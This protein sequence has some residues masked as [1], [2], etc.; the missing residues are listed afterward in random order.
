MRRLAVRY[1]DQ[2]RYF[3]VSPEPARLGSAPDNDLIAPFRGISRYHALLQPVAGN[4]LL[5][6]L[7]S[8]NGLVREGRRYSEVLLTP[9]RTIQLGHALLTLEEAPSGDVEIA[10]HLSPDRSESG[11]ASESATARLRGM[12][13]A[14]SPRAALRLVRELERLAPRELKAQCDAWLQRA[15][16]SLGAET[17][18]L[19]REEAL[20]SCAGPAPR[21]GS[22]RLALTGCARERPQLVAVFAT[23]P[24]PWQED[25]FNYLAEKLL[26]TALPFFSQAGSPATEAPLRFPAELITGTSSAFQ[27]ALRDLRLAA[28]SDL[29]VLILGETG[30][31]KELFART[32]HNSGPSAAGPFVALNCATVP[33]ELL[34]SELFGVAKGVATGVE[35]HKGL[36]EQ[37]ENGSLF[38]DEIGEMPERLQ[39]K[40][41]RVLQER[42]VRPLG[43]SKPRK[44][45]F[46]LL[47]A[48]N[49]DLI[50]LI[51]EGRFREDLYYRLRGFSLHLPALRE[52]R[53]DLPALAL[54]LVARAAAKNHKRIQG[55]SRR[56]LDLLLHHSWPGNVRELERILE[57]AV[58]RCLDG[59][60][61]QREHFPD[62]AE[63][64]EPT[65]KSPEV[66]EILPGIPEAKSLQEQV[67]TLEREAILRTLAKTHGNKTRAAAQLGLS[68]YGLQLKM[69]RLKI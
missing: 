40:L 19:F 12:S 2:V 69:A 37:A 31:G 28:R 3:P 63:P 38:L 46:R 18:A 55:L 26:G 1:A 16:Q 65:E 21:E 47:S 4:V 8:T 44:V 24:E 25:F 30:T 49:R 5:T 48:S 6:D 43:A 39:A 45:H 11:P 17:L 34:D 20:A 36:V 57:Q 62:L 64:A 41:L 59:G 42:E 15:R 7:G 58:V 53:D 22:P 10:L 33:G 66:A 14:A 13:S 52:R 27:E 51:A 9:G 67:D 29:P 23:E 32:L 54:S 50:A 61:L 35:P 60:M 56:V 68:R